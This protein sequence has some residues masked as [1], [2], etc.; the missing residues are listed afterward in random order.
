VAGDT[1]LSWSAPATGS[2]SFY[3]I[4]RDGTAVGVSRDR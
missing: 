4:Y 2:V 3:R 1:K